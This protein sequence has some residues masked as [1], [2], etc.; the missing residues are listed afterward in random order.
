MRGLRFSL[1]YRP[2]AQRWY[3]ETCLTEHWKPRA[4]SVAQ[5]AVRS[6]RPGYKEL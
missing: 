3:W 6:E 1:T 5:W 4:A 2:A